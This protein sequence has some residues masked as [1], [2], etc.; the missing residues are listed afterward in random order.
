MLQSLTRIPFGINIGVKSGSEFPGC[1]FYINVTME[2]YN[3]LFKQ[4]GNI[5]E[6]LTSL[7][8]S[9]PT[10]TPNKGMHH[11]Y[12]RAYTFTLAHAHTENTTMKLC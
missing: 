5:S 4:A 3:F 8:F 9:S 12:T 10:L 1:T 6:T 11:T 7:S 2:S